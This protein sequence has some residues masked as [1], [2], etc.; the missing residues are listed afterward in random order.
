MC[1][2]LVEVGPYSYLDL[3]KINLLEITLHTPAAICI[4]LQDFGVLLLPNPNLL[5]YRTLLK[6]ARSGGIFQA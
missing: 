3:V 1:R 6:T 2:G 4:Y 5:Y